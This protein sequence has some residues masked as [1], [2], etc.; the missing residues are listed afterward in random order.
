MSEDITLSVEKRDLL[1][2]KVKQLRRNGQTPAVIHDHGKQSVHI[3]VDE[4]NLKKAYSEAGKNHPVSVHV[5][6]KE[7]YAMIKDV[8]YAPASDIIQHVV[9][10]AVKADE[11]TTAEVPVRLVGDSPAEKASLQVLK[12]AE[13]LE[14]EALPRDLPESFE[15]DISQ[16][17]E[18]GDRISVGDI[19]PPANVEIK[20]DPTNLI[21]IVEEP[22]DQI[23]AADA[24]LE[25]KK[26]QEGE[27]AAEGEEAEEGAAEETA[28]GGEAAAVPSEHGDEPAKESEGEIRPGG[29]KG[30]E[31]KDQGHNPEKK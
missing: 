7:Y 18:I 15:V 24:A 9:F 20:T 19:P 10:Q 17:A 31:S 8:I 12:K 23:A 27:E 11:K 1:G 26:A 25:E 16:L 2:K 22:K 6:G 28:E 3:A 14:V 30:K 5:G 29:K 4:L 13:H 21:A